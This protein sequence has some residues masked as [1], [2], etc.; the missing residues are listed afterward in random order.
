MN[1]HMSPVSGSSAQSIK[2]DKKLNYEL[3][4][5]EQNLEDLIASETGVVTTICAK[6]STS[7]G[8]SDAD[9]PVEEED[10]EPGE[11]CDDFDP[12][13]DLTEWNV[14]YGEP[15]SLTTNFPSCAASSSSSSSSSS[16]A[17]AGP[18]SSPTS[19]LS[20]T[21]AAGRRKR[22]KTN[23]NTSISFP[24]DASA[25]DASQSAP[26]FEFLLSKRTLKR[27]YVKPYFVYKC[28]ICARKMNKLDVDHWLQHERE[29][30]GKLFPT[31]LGQP[32]VYQQTSVV[33]SSASPTSTTTAPSAATNAQQSTRTFDSFGLFLAHFNT[34]QQQQQNEPDKLINCLI[35]GGELKYTY[36]DVLKHFQSEHEFNVFDSSALKLADLELIYAMQANNLLQTSQSVCL[37]RHCH[38]RIPPLLVN[39]LAGPGCVVGR[40]DLIEREMRLLNE[41]YREQIVEKQ[42][43]S[44]LNTEQFY[45]RNF[46]YNSFV[47]VIC[48]TSK[49][50]IL[51]EHYH[52][53]A[54][55]A[56]TTTTSTSP[57]PAAAGPVDRLQFYSDEMKTVVLT[58]H[59][60]SHFNE[61]CYRCMSCKISWP[62]RTQLLKHA[63]ECS[64]SQVVRT[65]TKYKLKANCRLQ[66]K[67]YLHS[68]L[69]Y[70]QNE[71]YHLNRNLAELASPQPTETT[72]IQPISTMKV[73]LKDIFLNKKL[74]LDASS[75]FDLHKIHLADNRVINL[76]DEQ[77]Q[78]ETTA[79]P[80]SSSSS[81]PS[82]PPN[83]VQMREDYA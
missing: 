72:A 1:V 78:E 50:A 57:G 75:R 61:Y 47:C 53:K 64:N 18:L 28:L 13:I 67:F 5:F 55:A 19:Q 63:Q 76:S 31:G 22:F 38:I 21:Q 20:P 33:K 32:F 77:D 37:K 65:K 45:R 36:M 3:E 43:S 68:Y 59:V 29:S 11:L 73:F 9:A 26:A 60:L 80:S 40:C 4:L 16:S 24:G 58:N 25:N 15:V 44:W 49:L 10:E 23:N 83:D 70:W 81:T 52:L 82:A 79:A 35:C 54:A 69:D 2:R 7:V 71:K 6:S 27:F 41:I 62:D 12:S 34:Q 46:N 39:P 74:L 56:A 42:I 66:L 17:A 30:H 14:I 51:D 8:A 48:N